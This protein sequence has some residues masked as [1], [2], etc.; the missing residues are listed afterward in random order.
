MGCALPKA[1]VRGPLTGLRLSNSA[2]A[3][4]SKPPGNS[5]RSCQ[6]ISGGP[7]SDSKMS[8]TSATVAH[9][10]RPVDAD[11]GGVLIPEVC[12]DRLAISGGIGFVRWVLIGLTSSSP[13]D[14]CLSCDMHI[15][16]MTSDLKGGFPLRKYGKPPFGSLMGSTGYLGH[17]PSSS[18]DRLPLSRLRVN[19]IAMSQH[20]RQPRLGLRK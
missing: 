15:G 13:A 19:M 11:E 3:R 8:I 9:A 7:A 18:Q 14:S 10:L 1:V 12:P 17:L 16:Q 6:F 5:P 20:Q 2:S 4:P